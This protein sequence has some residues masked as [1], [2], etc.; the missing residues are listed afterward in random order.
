M[1]ILFVEDDPLDMMAFKRF[2][3]YNKSFKYEVEYSSEFEDAVYKIKNDSFSAVISDLHLSN[4]K[5]F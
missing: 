3:K 1:K 5:A 4:R 2:I